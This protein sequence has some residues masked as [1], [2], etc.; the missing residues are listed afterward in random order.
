V[1]DKITHIEICKNP[2]SLDFCYNF[3]VDESCGGIAI[4]VGTVRNL[5]KG[6]SVTH[7]D[8]ESY[9]PMAISELS[10][11]SETCRT[12]FKVS[13]IAIQHRTGEVGITEKAVIIAVSTIHRGEAFEA[14]SYIIDSL[15]E[16]VPIWKK[17]HLTD[18]SYWVNSRP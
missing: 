18:G 14:C 16:T 3:V 10:K 7:L 4:F 8:F 11:I 17:E 12:K 2:L 1:E 6:K 9:E 5:N 15:K 13:K